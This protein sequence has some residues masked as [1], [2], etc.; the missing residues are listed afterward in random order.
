VRKKTF[1]FYNQF[2]CNMSKKSVPS[3]YAICQ[4]KVWH[5][6]DILHILVKHFFLKYCINH[7]I[8]F[9]DILQTDKTYFLTYSIYGN[10]KFMVMEF[11]TTFNNISVIIAAVSQCLSSLMFWVCIP[12]MARC[13][14]VKFVSDLWQVGGF[15]RVE[16]AI[17]INFCFIR[18]RR[19]NFSYY[20]NKLFSLRINFPG[21]L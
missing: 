11:N 3:V 9:S 5:F 15:L 4:K 10:N 18:T 20:M 8:L 6:S 12:L 17:R 1:K 14:V 19:I 21:A 16:Y 7:E 2:E 13:Y